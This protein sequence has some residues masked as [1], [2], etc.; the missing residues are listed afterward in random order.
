MEKQHGAANFSAKC[1]N[2]E[3]KGYITI[4]KTSKYEA[5]PDENGLVKAS[6]AEFECRGVE[7]ME[8][9]M[10]EYFNVEVK[11]S[12]T[13]FEKADFTDLWCEYDDKISAVAQVEEPK[14]EVVRSREK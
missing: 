9:D 14:L 7:I 1:K 4:L 3:R 12:G 10:G 8:I 13:I 5:R 6:I 11:D 2:C